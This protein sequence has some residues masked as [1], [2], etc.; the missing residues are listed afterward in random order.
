MKIIDRLKKTK[1]YKSYFL[2]AILLITLIPIVIISYLDYHISKNILTEQVINKLDTLAD[3]K[4]QLIKT[5]ITNKQS[6][7]SL[8]SH[9][10]IVIKIFAKYDDETEGALR[11]YLSYYSEKSGFNKILLI[12]LDGSIISSFP[13]KVAEEEINPVLKR[14]VENAKTLL[15]LNMSNFISNKESNS[16]VA[17]MAAPVIQNG[18]AIGIAAV[19]MTNKEI[20]KILSYNSDLGKTG[21]TIGAVINDG[22]LEITTHL[23]D[24]TSPLDPKSEMN[25]YLQLAASGN[26]G[27]GTIIDYRGK[28]VLAAWR[29]IPSLRWGVLVKIDSDIA[30]YPIQQLGENFIILSL[31]GLGLISLIAWW[32]SKKLEQSK[33]FLKKIIDSILSP[34]VIVNPKLEVV[35]WNEALEKSL[36]LEGHNIP[37]NNLLKLF[38]S[39]APK[40]EQIYE[41]I[42]TQTSGKLNSIVDHKKEHYEIFVYPLSEKDFTG[43][44]VRID[45][46]TERVK[47]TEGLVQNDKLASIGILTAG[48][49]HEI[50]NPINFVVAS[51]DPLKKDIA[52]ILSVMEKYASL[53]PTQETEKINKLKK[54][55]DLDYSI[56]ETQQLLNGIEDG[57]KRTANIVKDLR[58]F[59]RLDESDMKN[60]NV[61]DGLNSTLTMLKNKYK[62]K[63]EVIKEYENIPTIDCY[64][65]K[66]NQVFMNV[67]SNAIDA[68]NTDGKIIIHT[69]KINEDKVGISIKDNGVGIPEEMQAKIFEPF[70]T[71]KEIGKGTGLGL[72]IS[73]GIIKEHKGEIQV[74]SKV[75]EGT[76][77]IIIL[78]IHHN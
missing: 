34:L 35:Q 6:N 13:A 73:Y 55:L 25:Q 45:N 1:I 67:L 36:N 58:S 70:F 21:E 68:V 66:L 26:Q 65:G 5:F 15:E 37:Q 20:D 16:L 76:E 41:L 12:S 61:H 24:K 30:L 18:K 33:I 53:N 8:F 29:Y 11:N 47:L 22:V 49:A 19:E 50:N 27:S 28:K 77:L 51:V 60:V 52:D 64:P 32:V 56:N 57:A 54:E 42:Q 48:I 23:K 3:N 46:I 10:P 44:V 2:Y 4:I 43:G 74:N 78:P 14:T 59:S 9:L 40:A 72:S 38:P 62:H 17:F 39:L 69:Y 75:G 31:L 71:T 63:A 7:L